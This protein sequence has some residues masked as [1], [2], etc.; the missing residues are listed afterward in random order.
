MVKG[1]WQETALITCRRQ[2]WIMFHLASRTAGNASQC[3]GLRGVVHCWCCKLHSLCC[4]CCIHARDAWLR[5][6]PSDCPS[7]LCI[8]AGL[9]V[10]RLPIPLGM[11]YACCSLMS[12]AGLDQCIAGWRYQQVAGW[13]R[14]FDVYMGSGMQP[15]RLKVHYAHMSFCNIS[16]SQWRPLQTVVFG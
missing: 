5:D 14:T 9:A 2:W 16:N 13:H 6:P 11:W 4:C 15:C 1:S 3:I 10:S 12:S 8:L 7:I